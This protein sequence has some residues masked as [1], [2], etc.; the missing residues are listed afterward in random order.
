MFSSSNVQSAAVLRKADGAKKVGHGS[1]TVEQYLS[2]Q[3]DLISLRLYGAAGADAENIYPALS[4]AI[5]DGKKNI[6]IP[7]AVFSCGTVID[8]GG[9]NLF[10]NG[11]YTG[12]G[13]RNAKFN[14]IT[15]QKDKAVIEVLEQPQRIAGRASPKLLF[16]RSETAFALFTRN[17]TDNEYIFTEVKQSSD[18]LPA[19][20][21][22]GTFELMRAQQRW[23]CEKVIVY[24]KNYDRAA[25][26]VT[27]L[28]NNLDIYF[29]SGGNTRLD[30]DNS[31]ANSIDAWYLHKGEYVEYDFAASFF[32]GRQFSATFLCTEFSS[33]AN[34]ILVNGV[35]VKSFSLVADAGLGTHIKTIYFDVPEKSPSSTVTVKIQ[36]NAAGISSTGA[37]LIGLNMSELKNYSGL[38]VDHFKAY[39]TTG[40]SYVS[41]NGAGEYAYQDEDTGLWSGSYHGGETSTYLRMIVGGTRYT[42]AAM[43]GFYIS[44]HIGVTQRTAL[45]NGSA[46]TFNTNSTLRWDV[47]GVEDFDCVVTGSGNAK[48]F[49]TMLFPTSDGYDHLLYPEFR[50]LGGTEFTGPI[51]DDDTDIVQYNSGSTQF[52]RHAFTRFN[53]S[54]N[55]FGGPHVWNRVGTYRK[56]YYGPVVNNPAQITRLKFRTSREFGRGKY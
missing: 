32:T 1:R 24:R 23:R 45:N 4:A 55:Q 22:G 47:D 14:G 46:N 39:Y 52:V 28:S 13:I 19:Q 3:E 25:A 50:N 36:N 34:E 12:G 33:E 41:T 49:Y 27:P 15:N 2:A 20:S 48:I 42:V 35:V 10:G 6:F 30:S 53:N 16:K 11:R 54:R 37:Y 44:N 29:V 51:N 9:A 26:G 18:S 7:N 21:V 40:D 38:P 17:A 8:C 5:A 43:S 31:N 56:V